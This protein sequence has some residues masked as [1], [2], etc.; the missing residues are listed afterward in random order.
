MIAPTGSAVAGNAARVMI[1]DDSAVIRGALDRVLRAGPGIEVVARVAHGQAALDALRTHDI[2]VVILDIEMP[3]MDGLTALPLLLAASPGLAV[4][5]ASTLTTRGGEISM[6]ALRMGAADTLS[7]P[8]TAELAPDG[9]FAAELVAK[10]LGLARLRRARRQAAPPPGAITLRAPPP[11]AARLLAIGS[12]TGGPNALF[13]L[14]QSLRPDLPVPVLITQ[15]MPAAFTP[16]LARHIDRLGV[17]PCS[18]AQD[19]EPVLPGRILIAPGE[20]H[21]LVRRRGTQLVVALSD[22]PAEHFCRPAVDPMLRS[23]AAATEGRLLVAMLTGMGQD[24]LAGAREVVAGGGAVVAQDED[25]S[26]VWGMPGAGGQGRP[27]LRRAAAAADRPPP[28]DH[29]RRHPCAC[30]PV[31]GAYAALSAMLKARSGLTLGP[32]KLYLLETRLA[33]LL[34]R[35]KLSGLDELAARCRPG[36]A[37]EADIVDAMTTNESLFFRDNRPFEVLRRILPRLHAARPPGQA[38][39]IWSAAAAHGQEAYSVAMVCHDLAPALA[40]RTFEIIGTD[41][42]R[43]PLE[44]ARQG[45]YSQFEIQRGLPMQMLVKHFVKEEQQ[46]R[47]RPALR[48]AVQFRQWNLLADLRPLG[49]FDVVFC[50]NVLIYFDPATKKRV[51]DAIARQM[52]ADGVLLLGGA[53]TVLGVTNALQP[54]AG[55]LGLCYQPAA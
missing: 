55:D 24:G 40:G 33:P 4:I 51:L 31:M 27:G 14:V 12:S 44:R 37:L 13:T 19:G 43:E 42:A 35:E 39:R 52:P 46:W 25:S 2:D 28:A 3:V 1:C 7:K 30:R 49:Q 29:A 23:A 50:R 34:R 21:L 36:S 41:I 11:R 16:V 45:L 18:Q 54:A 9:R 10:V 32:D 17:L 8:G 5:M 26:V 48:D 20:R 47:I 53:E 22:G 15:H 38:L 6:R